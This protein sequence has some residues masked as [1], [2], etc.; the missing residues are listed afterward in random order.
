MAEGDSRKP[1]CGVATSTRRL[2]WRSMTQFGRKAAAR[3]FSVDFFD[4]LT[5]LM[6]NSE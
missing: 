2:W 3:D 1:L 5:L 4:D 6:F